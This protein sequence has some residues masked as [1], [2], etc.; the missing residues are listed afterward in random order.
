MRPMMRPRVQAA[1]VE[2]N[3]RHAAQLTLRVSLDHWRA[4]LHDEERGIGSFA[5]TLDGLRWLR[6]QSIPIAIAGRLRWGDSDARP[7]RRLRRAL[8]A[9]AASRSTST[10]PRRW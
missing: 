9:R 10:T 6:D 5:E 1:L 8:R 2:L 3:R 7:A 4:D